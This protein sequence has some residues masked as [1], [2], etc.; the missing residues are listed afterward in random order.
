MSSSNLITKVELLDDQLSGFVTDLTDP[1][2]P[3]RVRIDV[4]GRQVAALMAGDFVDWRLLGGDFGQVSNELMSKIVRRR[5]LPAAFHYRIPD[6]IRRDIVHK[7]VVTAVLGNDVEQEIFRQDAN[8]AAVATARLRA[9]FAD[10]RMLDVV[11]VSQ[12]GADIVIQGWFSIPESEATHVGFVCNRRS[13]KKIDVRPSNAFDRNFYFSFWPDRPFYEFEASMPLAELPDGSA[14]YVIEGIDTRTGEPLFPHFETVLTRDWRER[15]RKPLPQA[16]QVGRNWRMQPSDQ[17][18]FM[19]LPNSQATTFFFTGSSHLTML[20]RAMRQS[21]KRGVADAERVLDWG[22]GVGRL[23]QH[24]AELPGCEVHGADI[25]A[26][27]VGWAS[28]NIPNAKFSVISRDPP[29]DYP[30]GY[31][32]LVIAISVF[33]HLSEAAQFAWLEELHRIVR[34]GGAIAVTVAGWHSF[35][36][37]RLKNILMFLRDLDRAGF[38]DSNI[39]NLLADVVG[40]ESIYYR[41]TKHMPDYIRRRWAPYFDIKAIELG[42]LGGLQDI[43]VALRPV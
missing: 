38:S 25:D 10:Y 30:D 4:D 36:R 22:C 14:G 33:T 21:I 16:A 40:K 12:I 18:E 9:F 43:V 42:A 32:D 27:N 7:V 34:P 13:F 37:G 17:P 19:N 5:V 28:S 23:T 11:A 29:T 15:I 26:E 3:R 39:G 8:L 41:N 35:R 6:H 2:R 20:D 31:F 24:L 1:L